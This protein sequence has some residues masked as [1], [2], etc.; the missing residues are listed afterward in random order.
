MKPEPLKGKKRF[1]EYWGNKKQ[2]KKPHKFNAFY[3][4]DVKSAVEWLKHEDYKIYQEIGKILKDI[5]PGLFTK[6]G[7]RLIRLQ[8][9][10]DKA[11]ED[12]TKER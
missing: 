1:F 3:E 7:G 8:L 9:N 11:F 12:V 5:H 10:R 6:V 2:L 4:D